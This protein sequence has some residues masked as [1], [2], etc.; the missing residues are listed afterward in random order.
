MVV[1]RAIYP[2]TDALLHRLFAPYGVDQLV[3][4]PVVIEEGEACVA[5]D[6]KFV[7]GQTAVQSFAALD[8]RYIYDGCCRLQMWI[9]SSDVLPDQYSTATTPATSMVCLAGDDNDDLAASAPSV[10]TKLAIMPTRLV[11]FSAPVPAIGEQP[12]VTH[13][14]PMATITGV[15]ATCSLEC[16]SHVVEESI[17]A[18]TQ[19]A[20]PT[21][22]ATVNSIPMLAAADDGTTDNKS[23][24]GVVSIAKKSPTHATTKPLAAADDDGEHDTLLL[25][26]AVLTPEFKV[27]IML[28]RSSTT[29]VG[30]VMS[31][32]RSAFLGHS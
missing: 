10:T 23:T 18:S 30:I 22:V 5:A 21:T 32:P 3:V 12:A 31:V 13:V 20:A 1:R 17:C 6:V 25:V 19:A 11:E 27:P 4:Y 7:S 8:G 26:A 9:A 29:E 15:P 24:K 28:S 2:I 14:V 16:P